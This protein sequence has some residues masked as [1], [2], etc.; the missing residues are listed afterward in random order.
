MT[1][2]MSLLDAVLEIE[3]TMSSHLKLRIKMIRDKRNVNEEND[4]E[5]LPITFANIYDSIDMFIFI[6]EFSNDQSN[7]ILLSQA[8]LHMTNIL[9]K[10]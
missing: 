4:D 7:I 3:N 10:M 1:N 2:L 5:E 6:K 9:L 8:C